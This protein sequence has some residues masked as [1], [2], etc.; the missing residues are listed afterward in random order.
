MV[1]LGNTTEKRVTGVSRGA[2]QP[3]SKAGL[4]PPLLCA[5]PTPEGSGQPRSRRALTLWW[6]HSQGY[7][8]CSDL[9]GGKNCAESDLRDK[10]QVK[11]SSL[12][13]PILRMRGTI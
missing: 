9:G 10:T 11:S 4:P 13:Q 1:T 12:T 3:F 8:A 6:P 2:T 5:P 7:C